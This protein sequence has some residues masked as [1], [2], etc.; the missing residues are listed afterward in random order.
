MIFSLVLYGQR[1]KPVK[2]NENKIQKRIKNWRGDHGDFN[3][4]IAHTIGTRGFDVTYF[5]GERTEMFIAN[6][7]HFIRNRIGFKIGGGYEFGSPFSVSYNGYYFQVQPFVNLLGIKQKLF[8]NLSSGLNIVRDEY[9][10][11]NEL[12]GVLS[13]GGVIQLE[14]EFVIQK[15]IAVISTIDQK[16]IRNN[17]RW[18]WGIGLRYIVF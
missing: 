1:R 7:Q 17:G 15:K 18:F 14:T 5:S 13:Y 6:Y 2:F 11:L 16:Y 9:S 10:R 3:L 8:L 4:D 12:D